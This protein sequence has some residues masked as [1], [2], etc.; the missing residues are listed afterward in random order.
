[1]RCRAIV[2]VAVVFA[3]ACIPKP[4]PI[5]DERKAYDRSGFREYILSAP[6]SG[7]AYPNKAVFG[8]KIELVGMDVEPRQVEPGDRASVS[9]YFKVLDYID[10]DWQIFVHMDSWGGFSERIHGDHY[11]V[12]GKYRTGYWQRGEIVKDVLRV[13]VP[14]DYNAQKIAVWMGL[15]IGDNRMPVDTSNKEVQQD[16]Q[17]R[18]NAGLIPIIL[19][20]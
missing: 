14:G 2:V 18:V 15:Y 19:K 10:E 6:P 11:P 7:I 12:F 8:K 3:A 5:D 9:F 13:K 16:G 17:N 20:K 4:Q 1:M